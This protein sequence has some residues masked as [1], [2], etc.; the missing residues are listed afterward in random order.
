MSSVLLKAYPSLRL[1]LICKLCRGDA[2]RVL[3]KNKCGLCRKTKKDYCD[4]N[5]EREVT[6]M[7]FLR[8]TW[9]KARQFL[10]NTTG[11]SKLDLVITLLFG[12]PHNGRWRDY[13][14]APD[15]AR[16]NLASGVVVRS[17]QLPDQYV[18]PPI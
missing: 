2:N 1:H 15:A 13:S 12:A 18:G 14:T 7:A 11:T 9:L 5:L 8:D 4:A 16:F 6:E 10:Q 17:V 3:G